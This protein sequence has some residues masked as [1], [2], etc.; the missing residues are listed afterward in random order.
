[1]SKDEITLKSAI[2]QGQMIRAGAISASELLD[3]HLERYHRYN[4]SINAI[5]FTQIERARRVARTLDKEHADGRHRGPLHGVTMT[6]KDSFDWQGA[7]STWGIPAMKD[8]YPPEDS[9]AVQRLEQA[10]LL[11]YGKSNVP[12]R[13]SD[14][15]S[16]NKF[17]G[18][19]NNP[20]DLS[21]TPG[22]SSGG[23]AAALATGMTSLEIGSDIGSSI[24]NPAH[25]CG[26]FGHK[27]T[28]GVVPLHGHMLPGDHA[29][30]DLLVGGPLARSAA[31]L[32]AAIDI[33]AG[34]GGYDARGWRL[35]LPPSKKKTLKDFKVGVMLESPVG[36]QD[37]ELTASLQKSLEQ[38]EH[39]G[40]MIDYSAAPAIDFKRYHHVYMLLLRSATGLALSHDEFASNLEASQMR[41]DTDWSHRAYV[42]RGAAI[43]QRDWWA[44]HNEREALRKAWDEFFAQYDLLLCPVAASAAFPH[45]HTGERPDRTIQINGQT[46][47]V[48]DQLF[49]AGISTLTH[50][51][52]S[53]V[54][55][56]LTQSG[57]PCGLQ[58]IGNFLE[59][60]TTLEFAHLMEQA[61]GGFQCVPGYT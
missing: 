36:V 13:I 52:S 17:Y 42:E 26:V 40:V 24:R 7:P 46:Q 51:P 22:G 47:S 44:L 28:M 50:L 9:L 43:R 34:P 6:V 60:Y 57:L 25:Y 3:L 35:T 15:Q 39:A 32:I 10:G 19:T 58:I 18:T 1:M 21:R 31:D 5:V 20:W 12:F 61:I 29:F 30:I 11:I 38:L 27:P 54:P 4:P 2:A 16:F 33:L 59:D 41:A 23:A 53:V 8:N 48:I 37:N 56:G 49:W 45:D 55:A 14:W